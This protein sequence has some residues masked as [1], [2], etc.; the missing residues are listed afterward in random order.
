MTPTIAA[1]RHLGDRVEVR[2]DDGVTECWP[3]IWLRHACACEGCGSSVKGLRP[4]FCD[5]P[6]QNGVPAVS[7]EADSIT[8]DWG[9]GHRS[10]YQG[11]WLRGHRLSPEGLR[12]REPRPQVWSGELELPAPVPFVDARHNAAAHLDLLVQ[13]RDR[14]FALLAGVPSDWER[15]DEI[16]SLFGPRRITNYSGGIYE[17]RTKPDPEISGDMAVPLDPHTDEMYRLEPPAITLFQV[18]QPA[19][20]GG[21]STLVDGLR[22]AERLAAEAPEA[23]EA[24]TTVPARFHREL[25]DGHLFD[26]EALVLPRDQY[27]SV[28]G[29]RF[30]DRCL[31]PVVA[32]PEDVVRFY[33]AVE[34]LFAMIVDG[35]DTIEL[36]LGRGDMLVFNNHRVL[37]GRTGFEPASGRH[38]RSFHVELDEFHSTLRGALRRAGSPDQWMRLGAMAHA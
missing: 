38:V 19:A 17:L 3:D 24:L 26:L 34:V 22:L 9:G 10:R 37:H 28:C 12:A 15:V 21:R 25:D 8:V 23:F 27:G 7:V 20:V 31:A 16:A 35:A 30:N 1:T 4:R 36:G 33:A 14:G 13:I 18:V 11:A 2:W 5:R 6:G 32:D 29:I